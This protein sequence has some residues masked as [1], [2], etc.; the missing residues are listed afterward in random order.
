MGNLSLNPYLFFDGNCREAMKFYQGIFG[1][2]LQMQTFGEVDNSCPVAMKDRIMH[3]SLMG[4]EV[5][6]MGSDGPGNLPLGAGKVSLALS[7]SEE[8]KLR[9]IFE[10]LGKGGKINMPLEKQVWGDIYGDLTDKFHVTWM[11]NIGAQKI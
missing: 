5:N 7:G 4:G 9:K 2:A 11:V 3:A 1:G 6:F 8:Q 10:D